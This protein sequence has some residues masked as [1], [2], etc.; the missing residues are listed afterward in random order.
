MTLGRFPDISIEKART[1]AA[2]I[3]ATIA[4]GD[5]PADAMRKFRK[6][7]TLGELFSDY[8]ERHAKIYKKSW[9]ED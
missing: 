2:E 4:K 7:P 3:N 1:M 9:V 6:E 5:N 8:L